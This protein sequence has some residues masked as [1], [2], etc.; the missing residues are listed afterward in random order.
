MKPSEAL[1]K[2]REAILAV[3]ARYR[4][5]NPL[6]FGSALHG[7]DREDSDLDILVDAV[8]RAT[9]FDLGGIVA[10]FPGRGSC[11]GLAHMSRSR[12]IIV[13]ADMYQSALG[14]CGRAWW[15]CAIGSRMAARIST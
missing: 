5:A 13:L 9:L 14:S 3:V 7:D 15:A 1:E 12:A 10:V 8:S 2:H 6:V 11:G 4:V